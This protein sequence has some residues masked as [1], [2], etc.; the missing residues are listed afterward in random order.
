MGHR[1]CKPREVVRATTQRGVKLT[2][3]PKAMLGRIA[4]QKHF[5]QNPVRPLFHFAKALGV[6]TRLRVAFEAGQT[7]RETELP[8]PRRSWDIARATRV[9]AARLRRFCLLVDTTARLCPRREE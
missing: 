8:S 3:T 6:H 5:V 7:V 9:T 1:D 4:L 2:P